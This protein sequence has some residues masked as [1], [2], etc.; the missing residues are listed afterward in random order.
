MNNDDR[1]HHGAP[2]S[3][4]CCQRNKMYTVRDARFLRFL[5]Q[6]GKSD[7]YI[8]KLMHRGQYAIEL[9]TTGT[10]RPKI[11]TKLDWTIETP[12]TAEETWMVVSNWNVYDHLHLHDMIS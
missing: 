3:W 8:A 12:I 6:K 1:C 11:F 7:A 5:Y 9:I 10:V 2:C 4:C